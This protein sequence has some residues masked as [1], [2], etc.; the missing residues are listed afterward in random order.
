MSSTKVL[1]V[2]DEVGVLNA[3]QR[4]LR[5]ESF[6]V[7]A[8][9]SPEEALQWAASEPYALVLSDQ[10]MPGM[11]GTQLL[12]KIRAI[13]PETVRIIMTGYADMQAAMDAINRGE[14]YR[15]LTKPWND[16]ELKA[17]VRQGVDHY[18]LIQRNKY[19][20]GLTEAQNLELKDL[21]QNLEKKVISRTQ[22]ISKLNQD[23]SKLNLQLEKSFLETVQVLSG[24][25]EMHSTVIG[26]HSKRVAALARDVA[27][28]M[29]YTGGK[30]FEL[31]IAALL[32]DVGKVAVPSEILS[33]PESA[34]NAYEKEVLRCHSIKGETLLRMVSDMGDVARMIRLHHERFDGTGYPEGL[35]GDRIPLGARIIAAANAFDRALNS[36]AVYENAT[37]ELAL[38]Y[39]QGQCPRA[40][41]PEVVN[42]LCMCVR[43][44]GPEFGLDTVVEIRPKDLRVGMTLSQEL[45]TVHGVLLL[46]KDTRISEVYLE[47]ILNFQETDP[48]VDSI[49]VYRKAP[50]AVG[51]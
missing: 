13:S 4:I 16:A 20:Q 50:Q 12:E 28:E 24:L 44:A 23:L 34:L 5:N 39:V 51:K 29:N 47:K 38:R 6:Q 26:N 7:V 43:D 36:R 17:T 10:K 15:F 19:L 49:Y 9:T 46:P 18:D 1:L 40:F 21:N 22:E 42:I 11:E 32:H 45:R 14:V 33:K 30:L 25:S 3:Y 8:T 48:V 31:E 37:S 2:D 35:K 41:D 27:V